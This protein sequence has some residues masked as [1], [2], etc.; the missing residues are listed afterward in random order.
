MLSVPLSADE[1]EIKKKKIPEGIKKWWNEKPYKL[2]IKDRDCGDITYTII[3]SPEE[4]ADQAEAHYV[5]RLYNMPYKYKYIPGTKTPAYFFSAQPGSALRTLPIHP[6]TRDAALGRSW[7]DAENA[8]RRAAWNLGD[9]RSCTSEDPSSD[10]FLEVHEYAHMLG[11]KDAYGRYGIKFD[12]KESGGVSRNILE[13][14]T[15]SG[16]LG[17]SLVSA[18]NKLPEHNNAYIL[19]IVWAVDRHIREV[20]N[21]RIE[22]WE[23]IS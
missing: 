11:I 6:F 4:V 19:P 2:R 1:Y 15:R 17:S 20:W 3:F 7:V 8:N 18:P 16:N 14:S 22:E 12:D 23:I 5:I 10:G 13:I 9:P 21:G